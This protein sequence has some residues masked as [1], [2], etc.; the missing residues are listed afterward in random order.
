MLGQMKLQIVLFGQMFHLLKA[1]DPVTDHQ[2]G[3]RD[4][5]QTFCWV[6]LRTRVVSQVLLELRRVSCIGQ[7]WMRQ[8]SE[9][10]AQVSRLHFRCALGARGVR[11]NHDK[12]AIASDRELVAQCTLGAG[13]SESVGY[14]L[15]DGPLRHQRDVTARELLRC[16]Y[17]ADGRGPG[18]SATLNQDA[19]PGAVEGRL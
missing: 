3:L 13:R 9:D 10:M 17:V 5:L 11:R 15:E 14:L 19:G 4:M 12:A 1:R 8:D 18:R 16:L 6:V 7:Y 2:L